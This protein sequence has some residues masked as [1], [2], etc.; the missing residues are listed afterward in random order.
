MA[1][2]QQISGINDQYGRGDPTSK[3]I[4]DIKSNDNDGKMEQLRSF[5][6]DTT[7]HG[8]RFLFADNICRRFLWTLAVIACFIHCCYQVFTC[9]SEFKKRPFNTKITVNASTDNGVSFPAVTLCNL[10]SLNT[11]RFVQIMSMHENRSTIER[12]LRDISLLSSRSKEISSQGFQNRNPGLFR[13]QSTA[14]TTK[15][16]QELFSHQIEEMFLPGSPDFESCS[17]NGKPCDVKHFTSYKS[18]MFGKCYTFNS[19][20]GD[21]PPL[22]K[23]TLAGQNSGLKLRLN[24]EREGYL[25]STLNPF[26]GLAILIHDQKAFPIMEEFGIKV[27]PGVST[28]CAIKKRKVCILLTFNSSTQLASL[29]TDSDRCTSSIELFYSLRHKERRDKGKKAMHY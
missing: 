15:Q 8:A 24:I 4:E 12:K 18:F 26:V 11:R 14:D 3:D 9:V 21:N 22:Q 17:F 29:S 25:K 20:E 16:L 2:P 23:S 7:L 1:F 10:N 5:A 27:Q 28:L 19:V 6:Q 13:R